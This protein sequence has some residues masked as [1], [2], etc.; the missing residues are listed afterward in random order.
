MILLASEG[1]GFG[2]S[3]GVGLIGFLVIGGIAFIL[4]VLYRSMRRQLKRIDF[5]PDGS[6]DLERMSGHDAR[7]DGGGPPG[8]VL[9]ADPP[10]GNIPNGDVPRSDPGTGDAP[11]GHR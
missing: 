11:N 4:F 1:D 8:D 6:T 3:F 7:G 5:N 9:D 2:T 10:N